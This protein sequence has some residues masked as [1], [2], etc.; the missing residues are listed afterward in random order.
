MQ[1]SQIQVIM[2]R[3]FMSFGYCLLNASIYP[4]ALH[5]IANVEIGKGFVGINGIIRTFDQVGIYLSAILA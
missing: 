5:G 1:S 2:K 3:K 4:H